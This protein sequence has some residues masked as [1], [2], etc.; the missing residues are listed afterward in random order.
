MLVKS[1]ALAGY[2][3]DRAREEDRIQRRPSALIQNEHARK[4]WDTHFADQV[5]FWKVCFSS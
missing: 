1:E 4:F 3:R 2:T 5:K